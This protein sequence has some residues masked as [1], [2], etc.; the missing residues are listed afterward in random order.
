MKTVKVVCEAC[1]GTGQVFQH[2]KKH[3]ENPTLSC[4][5]CWCG[6]V[7]CPICK[8]KTYLIKELS[9]K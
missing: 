5:A 4:W 2:S 3:D 1:K 6:D 9:P 7:T 8:G